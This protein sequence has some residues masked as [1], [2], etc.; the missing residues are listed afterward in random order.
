M[1]FNHLKEVNE[2]WWQHFCFAF[3]MCC[4]L[5]WGGIRIGIH[6]F[7]PFL[8]VTDGSDTIRRCYRIVN[9][10]F[11]EQYGKSRIVNR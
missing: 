7:L 1:N 6:A 9:E 4:R 5:L 10:K 8:F 11:P 2:S 3:P